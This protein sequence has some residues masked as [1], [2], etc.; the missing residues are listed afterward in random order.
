M[1][2]L[3]EKYFP[4][5]HKTISQD[6]HEKTIMYDYRNQVKVTAENIVGLPFESKGYPR[7]AKIK[8][9]KARPINS[10]I[11]NVLL[12]RHS[13]RVFNKAPL[14]INDLSSLLYYSAGVHELKSEKINSRSYPSAGGKYPLEIYPVIINVK[15]IKSGIY[16]YHVRSHSLEQILLG[17]NCLRSFYSCFNQEWIRQASA[18][19]LI[20][21]IFWKNQIKYGERGYRYS[22]L[23][24]GHLC[25][26][27][28]L[29]SE[30][31][32]LGCC[33]IGGFLDNKL[34]ALLDIPTQVESVLVAVAVGN[35]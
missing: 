34:N 20:S 15:D 7:F 12:T 8:L 14:A 24:A 23:D 13:T 2:D 19:F 30:S 3:L 18:I 25:Q 11:S 28:Y 6:F 9:P 17:N 32:N 16:H 5:L 26:N 29:V 35:K 21:S 31:M 22:L 27:L 1:N 4:F 10:L 33:E